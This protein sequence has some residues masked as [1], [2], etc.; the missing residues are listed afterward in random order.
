[1][2]PLDIII[3]VYRGLEET[4]ECINST[5]PTLPNWAQLIVINDASPDAELTDWLREQAATGA[6]VLLE[7]EQ[8]L[9]FV[10][11]VNRGMALNA[12][13]DVLLLNS[14]VEVPNSDWLTRMR[15]AAYAHDKVASLTPF[16]NNATICSFPNFCADNELFSGLN[17]TELDAVFAELPISDPLVAVPTGVGFCMYMRRDC[18]NEVGLFDEPTFGKGYGEENDWC[19]RALKLGFVNYHQLNVFAYHKG[20]VSF[21]EEGDPRKAKAI[22]L[23]LGLHPDYNEQVQRF[24]RQDPA[25][26]ARLLAAMALTRQ[27]SA[28]RVLLISHRLGGGVTQHLNELQTFYGRQARFLRLAPT[29]EPGTVALTLDPGSSD[30]LYFNVQQP[31][32]YQRLLTV[33]RWLGVTKLHFHHTMG[34]P[35]PIFG[36]HVALNVT[37]D[38]SVHDYYLLNANPTLTSALGL[39]AGDEPLARD[40]ACAVHYP[41]PNNISASAWREQQLAWLL[42]AER[43]IFPSTDV[44][45]R[46]LAGF[47]EPALAAKAIVAWHLDSEQAEWPEVRAIATPGAPPLSAQTASAKPLKV[48]VLGALSKEKGALLLEQV[49]GQLAGEVEFHLLGYGFKPLNDVQTHGAYQAEN[50]TAK[51][52]A[53]NADVVWFPAQW[54]ETYSYTLSIALSLGLPVVYPDLGAF[55][56]RTQGRASSYMLPWQLPVAQLAEFWRALAQGAAVEHFLALA[57][58]SVAYSAT[59]LRMVNFYQQ[60]YL[61]NIPAKAKVEESVAVSLSQAEDLLQAMKIEP[62]AAVLTAKERLLLVLWRV[63]NRPGICGLLN[64]IPYAWQQKLK[65]RLSHKSIHEILPK[66]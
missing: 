50:L 6:F 29:G 44:A 27:H 34:L 24:I 25:K 12:D 47:N 63:K 20:G 15:S 21:Q 61:R 9:G 33:L 49:A 17:V 45:S 3:P 53:I 39:F 54:P 56:E 57:P 42:A 32:Q 37:Y 36:L 22:E 11:T 41:L 59:P 8:N 52:A 5:T 4:Q 38:V 19:Q 26:Q 40:S 65:Q 60:A 2:N 7:N 35:E 48:L 66:E 31:E 30:A 10:G 55:A 14:D 46:L 51:L 43:I 62:M 64:L 1:M 58:I 28:P 13:R 16:S 23:L 18:M